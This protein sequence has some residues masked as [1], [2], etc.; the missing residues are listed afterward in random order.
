[1]C[2]RQKYGVLVKGIFPFYAVAVASSIACDGMGGC[3][4]I[5][6]DRTL[7]STNPWKWHLILQYR[8]HGSNLSS[9]ADESHNG[10]HVHFALPERD[11]LSYLF[12][13]RWFGRGWPTSLAPLTWA[14]RGPHFT[15]PDNSLWDSINRR[16]SVP[17]CN[18]NEECQRAAEG[19]F[20]TNAPTHVTEDMEAH[21]L[22]CPA[23]RCTYG[24]TGHVTKK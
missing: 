4:I 21:P 1:M 14:P 2:E 11:V 5:L 13:G 3:D 7:F 15:T 20:R 8:T 22:L 17:R 10:A 6:P 24:S 23:S 19:L 12:P 16:M 9:E 18:T